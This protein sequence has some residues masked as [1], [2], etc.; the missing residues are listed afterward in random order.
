MVKR[1]AAA[2]TTPKKKE[3]L[4]VSNIEQDYITKVSFQ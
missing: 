4:N 2:K 3:Q 1:K